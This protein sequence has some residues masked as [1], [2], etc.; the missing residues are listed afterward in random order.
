MINLK[1]SGTA[2]PSVQM[3][4]QCLINII[5]DEISKVLSE[6]FNIDAF[7][8]SKIKNNEEYADNVIKAAKKI[9]S[10]FDPDLY[11]VLEGTYVV[12]SSKDIDKFYEN[13]PYYEKISDQEYQDMR[14]RDKLL[15]LRSVN[16]TAKTYKVKKG[17]NLT[18]IAKKFSVDLRSLIHYNSG[19]IKNPDLI[20]PGDE[21]Y[22]PSQEQSGETSGL[23]YGQMYGDLSE[24]GEKPI[25]MYTNWIINK[26]TNL[27]TRARL[28]INKKYQNNQINYEETVKLIKKTKKRIFLLLSIEVAATFV[29]EI[30][31][32]TD[33]LM[34]DNT[35]S[36]YDSGTNAF[37]DM[38]Y[39]YNQEEIRAFQYE[40]KFF[41]KILNSDIIKDAG[42]VKKFVNRMAENSSTR[43]ITWEY[44]KN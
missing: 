8:R 18:K 7:Y 32:L 30:F 13:L 41:K 42:W 37:A 9:V 22:I 36:V 26:K 2:V 17:D 44:H 16:D 35:F 20:Y 29:H 6:N 34:R 10:L 23:T 25:T 14:S 12:R 15:P 28:F 19:I 3:Y 38:D 27:Q 4:K 43:T 31:H 21:I 39:E 24:I 1:E 40:S 5:E 33:E 11:K